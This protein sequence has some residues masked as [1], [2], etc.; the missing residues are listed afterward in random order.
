VVPVKH[1]A[2][3]QLV[4]FFKHNDTALGIIDDN[5]ANRGRSAKVARGTESALACYKELYRERQKAAHQLSLHHFFKRVESCQS[6]D[7]EPSTSA[8][9]SA[10]PDLALPPP[11]SPESSD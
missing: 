5:D 3:K 9:E 8:G 2:T 1:L 11:A 10:Q 4:E 7:L 6:T